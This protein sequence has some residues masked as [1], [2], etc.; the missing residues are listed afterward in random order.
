MKDKT[1]ELYFIAIIPPRPLREEIRA[2][3]ERIRDR[4]G[5]GH[6][7]K[8]PAHITLQMPFKRKPS[9]EG[10]LSAELKRF[11]LAEKGFMVIPDGY[12]AFQPRVI[13]I[14][15]ANPEPVRSLHKRLR[16]M[17][18]TELDFSQEE[19][20]EEFHPHIS[21]ATRDL[22]RSAFSEAWPEF[23]DEKFTGEFWVGSIFLLKHN[24]RNWD[25]HEEY[26]FGEQ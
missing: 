3:K 9:D 5:A 14:S 23:R 8:S 12:G 7:L 11:S 6:A 1:Q 19:I 17:L 20:K 22:A 21:V 18:L 13:Y 25:I 2:I 24:G 26:L 4:F 16:E 10:R 15:V